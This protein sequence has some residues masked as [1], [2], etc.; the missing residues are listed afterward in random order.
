MNRA[1][2]AIDGIDERYGGKMRSVR[3]VRPL[4]LVLLAIMAVVAI[5]SG[6]GILA[7]GEQQK[8]HRQ[9]DLTAM[10]HTHGTISLQEHSLVDVLSKLSLSLQLNRVA[11]HD[12]GLAIDLKLSAAALNP[13]IVYEDMAELLR[14]CFVETNNVERLF[15]RI[16]IHD[17]QAVKKHV[18]L[19]MDALKSQ[20]TAERILTLKQ[21]MATSNSDTVQ[22]LRMTYTPLWKRQFGSIFV[23]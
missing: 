20:A 22:A 11:F 7:A 5:T 14:F 18:L 3:D 6:L 4:K 23:Q 12:K 1:G 16:L 19:A 8:L 9:H 10:T 17:E 15:L 13:A 2:A 21:G